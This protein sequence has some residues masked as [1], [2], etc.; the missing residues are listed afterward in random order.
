MW[1]SRKKAKEVGT[2]RAQ[3]KAWDEVEVKVRLGSREIQVESETE[4]RLW[5]TTNKTMDL[6]L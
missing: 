1:N 4:G 3:V 6:W 2:N 5:G